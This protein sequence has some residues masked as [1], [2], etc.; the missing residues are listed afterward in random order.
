MAPGEHI[1]IKSDGNAQSLRRLGADQEALE[2]A[3]RNCAA[4]REKGQLSGQLGQAMVAATCTFRARL[5]VDLEAAEADARW[6]QKQPVV[7]GPI[8]PIVKLVG[9]VD[10]LLARERWTQALPL[11]E[12]VMST[13]RT[14]GVPAAMLGT[15]HQQLG[16][17]RLGLGETAAAVA[18]LERACEL[19]DG[20]L[21]ATDPRLER[22]RALILAAR[23]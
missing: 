10:V 11:C 23:K 9:H 19:W 8:D 20:E 6:L 16:R 13:A 18:L 12:T 21:E 5:G 22:T 3:L 2:H 15:A 17:C 1:G 7:F 4:L 14:P